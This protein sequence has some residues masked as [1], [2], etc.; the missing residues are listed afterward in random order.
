MTVLEILAIICGLI[1]IAGSILPALPGPPISWLGLL[2]LYFAG[3][4]GDCDPVTVKFLVIWL[5]IVTIVAILD[6]IVPAWF[7]KVTGGH[8]AASWGSIIGLFVGMFS[9]VGIIVG[10]LLGAFIGEFFWEQKGVWESFKASIGAFFG[11]IFGH[12]NQAYGFGRDDVL[13]H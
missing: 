7:T 12:R 2:I 13:H 10:S 11:F 4:R 9:P 1:G 5:I 8:K 3:Q 6:Y